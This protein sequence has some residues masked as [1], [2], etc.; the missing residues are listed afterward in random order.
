MHII[1]SVSGAFGAIFHYEYFIKNYYYSIKKI[2]MAV[3]QSGNI[4]KL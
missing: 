2:A 4:Y 3:I 1:G